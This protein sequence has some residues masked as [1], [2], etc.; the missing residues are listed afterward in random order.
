MK[1]LEVFIKSK[2]RGFVMLKSWLTKIRRDDSPTPPSDAETPD[3]PPVL[4]EGSISPETLSPPAEAFPEKKK[5][6]SRVTA[7]RR[8]SSAPPV[9]KPNRGFMS[10]PRSSR[11]KGG[12]LENTKAY[13]LNVSKTPF[14]R[15]PG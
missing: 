10:P 6:G 2:K 4:G 8:V 12:T 3:E 11:E 1:R 5:L 7:K 15:G 9:A 14:R 13:G